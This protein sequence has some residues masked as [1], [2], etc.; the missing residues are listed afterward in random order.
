MELGT[1][2]NTR[3]CLQTALAKIVLENGM[4]VAETAENVCEEPKGSY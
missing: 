4:Q 3:F 2:S 1:C